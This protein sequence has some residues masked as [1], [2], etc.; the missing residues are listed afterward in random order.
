MSKFVSLGLLRLT[1][2]G[3]HDTLSK[4]FHAKSWYLKG[5]SRYE[6]HVLKYGHSWDGS[7]ALVGGILEGVAYIAAIPDNQQTKRSK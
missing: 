5:S 7:L 4:A 1:T 6:L 2:F 3:T